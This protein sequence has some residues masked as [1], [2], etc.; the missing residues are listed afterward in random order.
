MHR[1]GKKDCP[2]DANPQRL[3]RINPVVG[4]I[5]A[6]VRRAQRGE[7]QCGAKQGSRHKEKIKSNSQWFGSS[8]KK[9]YANITD[10]QLRIATG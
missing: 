9:R 3:E 6:D 10:D 2:K 4:V 1:D 5:H 8:K 7:T